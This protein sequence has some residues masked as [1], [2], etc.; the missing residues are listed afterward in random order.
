M[1]IGSAGDG[2]REGG[3]GRGGQGKE[4]EAMRAKQRGQGKEGKAKRA[5][6]KSIKLATPQPDGLLCSPSPIHPRSLRVGRDRLSQV[7]RPAQTKT[8]TKTQTRTQTKKD[9]MKFA[10]QAALLATMAS[11]VKAM[12]MTSDKEQLPLVDSESLRETIQVTTLLAKLEGLQEM[13][14]ETNSGS[15]FIGSTGHAFTLDYIYDKLYRTGYYDITI[16]DFLVTYEEAFLSANGD[17]YLAAPFFY[18][19]LGST[20]A[21]LIAVA[22]QGCQE[23]DYPPEVKNKIVIITRGV[24]AYDRKSTLAKQAGAAGAI[25]YNIFDGDVVLEAQFNAAGNYVPTVGVSWETGQALLKSLGTANLEISTKN[26]PTKNIIAETR[27]GD[28]NNVLML[29]AHTDSVR[30]GPG[31]NDNGSGVIGLLEVAL[32]LS[33]FRVQNAVRFGFWSAGQLGM[34]GSTRYVNKL[35]QPESRKIRLYLDFD[36]IASPNYVYEVLDGSGLTFGR[37]GAPGSAEVQ[38]L[39][40]DYFKGIKIKTKSVHIGSF[41]DNLPFFSAGIPIGGLSSGADEIKSHKEFKDHG[42]RA[43]EFYDPNHKTSQDRIENINKD[44]FLQITRAIAHAVATYA[45][46]FESLGARGDAVADGTEG[47][48]SGASQ[49]EPAEKNG[50]MWQWG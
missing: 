14:V 45:R 38:T 36:T 5:R 24:C 28:H 33:K 23:A 32:R 48:T 17:E 20:T 21:P 9:K 31:I 25:I 1:L 44:V 37:R 41:G 27:A 12:P 50:W 22:N 11:W 6:Q 49:A 16:Q 34:L 42:G 26:V 8:Q 7:K 40:Q 15:R 19:P 39:W 2:A 10:Q 29:G 43:G 35:S 4:S 3:P 46:T 30:S 47:Q 18:S 13:T